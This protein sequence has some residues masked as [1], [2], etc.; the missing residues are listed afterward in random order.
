MMKEN[1][2]WIWAILEW[3]EQN[4]VIWKPMRRLFQVG[5]KKKKK[6]YALTLEQIWHIRRSKPLV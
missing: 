4:N 5:E 1:Y 3:K 6:L 2:M